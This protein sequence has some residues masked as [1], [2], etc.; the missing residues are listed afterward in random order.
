MQDIPMTSKD[1]SKNCLMI[2]E[3][4]LRMNL[5]SLQVDLLFRLFQN[6][7]DR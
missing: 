4:K 6:R 7:V 1:V 2:E 3:G 5:E